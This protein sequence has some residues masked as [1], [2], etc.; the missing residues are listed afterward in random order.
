MAWLQKRPQI[1]DGV[2]FYS[3]SLNKTKLLVGLGNPEEKYAQTRHNIGF[4]CLDA[5]VANMDDMGSWMLKKDLKCI[6]SS[7][8]VGD[9]QVIAIKPTTF[10]N[11]SGEAVQAVTSFYKI[12]PA[13]T[14]VIHDELDIDFGYIRLRNGGSSAGHNGLKSI[15][16]QF[17]EDFNRIRIGIGPKQP[18]QIDSAAFVLQRF[19]QTET[20]QLPNLHKEVTAILSEFIYGDL[21]QAET[22]TFLV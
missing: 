2:Q 18:S 5:F 9:T 1:G 12:S 7:G 6:F 13:Q 20:G 14:V 21:L 3:M 22:R 16:Q 17:G 11:L 15:I 19:T 4:S 10:M 8:K